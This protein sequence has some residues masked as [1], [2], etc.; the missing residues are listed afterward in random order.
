MSE[1]ER[2]MANSALAAPCDG[3]VTHVASQVGEVAVQNMVVM[4]LANEVVFESY[5]DQTGID[6][7]K[8]G[9]SATVRLSPIQAN[10]FKARLCELTPVST[11]RGV[12][13]NAAVPIRGSRIRHGSSSRIDD[14]PPGP[15][16][17]R[18]VQ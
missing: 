2:D 14:L 9:D 7:V 12:Q 16:R 10:S 11:R 4:N 8:P 6:A 5:I 1:A 15:A 18:R 17:P 3:L 13:R